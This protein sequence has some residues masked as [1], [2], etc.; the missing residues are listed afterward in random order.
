GADRWDRRFCGKRKGWRENTSPSVRAVDRGHARS[1]QP[2]TARVL[3]MHCIDELLVAP[4]TPA[5]HS[6][7]ATTPWHCGE[8]T[9]P[10]PWWPPPARR[11]DRT[12]RSGRT[13]PVSS[14]SS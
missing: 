9:A 5:T 2:P 11:V 10:P 4:E 14:S 3:P 7:T 13:S 12:A 8:T 6:L 1:G